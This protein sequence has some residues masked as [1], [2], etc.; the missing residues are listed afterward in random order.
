M[1]GGEWCL[2]QVWLRVWIGPLSNTRLICYEGLLCRRVCGEILG[3]QCGR[4]GDEWRRRQ[5]AEER[6]MW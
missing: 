3:R 1:R 2:M 4:L 5:R 6:C